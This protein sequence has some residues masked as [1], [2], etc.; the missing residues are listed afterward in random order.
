REEPDDDDEDGEDGDEEETVDTGPDPVVT[1]ENFAELQKLYDKAWD[2]LLKRGSHDKKTQEKREAVA[3]H[4]MIFKL[5]PKI[6]DEVTRNLRDK[7]D[8]IRRTERQIMRICV[9]DAGMG[10][11]EF[12]KIYREAGGAT[13]PDWIN[14]AIRAKRK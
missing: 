11:D 6:V 14:K 9:V 2:A 1:A 4:I 10:R 8:L 3:R 12:L 5:S 13:N 7:I